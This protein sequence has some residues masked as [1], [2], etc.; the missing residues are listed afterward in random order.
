[1]KTKN[2]FNKK[3]INP[4]DYA[5]IHTGETLSSEYANVGSPYF[6]ASFL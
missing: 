2:V 1:M 3:K 5:N 4:D 6:S